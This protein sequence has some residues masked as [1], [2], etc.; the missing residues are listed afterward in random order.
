MS[1]L[2]FLSK[3]LKKVVLKQLLAHPKSNN[4]VEP[5]QSAYKANHSTETAILRV[6]NDILFEADNRK[7]VMLNLLHLSAAFDTIDH[8]IILKRLELTFRIKGCVLRWF[9]SYLSNRY[10]TVVIGNEM[11]YKCPL[12]YGVHQGSVLGPVLFTIYTQPLAGVIK[13]FMYSITFMPT[14]HRSLALFSPTKVI[15][16]FSI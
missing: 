7:V 10:Q 16:S 9:M 8:N 14:I 13:N 2:P 15:V 4:L 1:N 5:F 11:S 3:I 6:V 12:K